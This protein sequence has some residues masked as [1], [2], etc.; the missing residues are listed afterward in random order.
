M[1]GIMIMVDLVSTGWK[2]IFKEIMKWHRLKN[3]QNPF[4]IEDLLENKG[5]IR[6]KQTKEL[7]NNIMSK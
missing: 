7:F 1:F 3:G 6:E 5:L 2:L 4:L